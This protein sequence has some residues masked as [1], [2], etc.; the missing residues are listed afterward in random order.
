MSPTAV[1]PEAQDKRC[2]RCALFYRR[3]AARSFAHRI[4]IYFAHHIR[5]TLICDVAT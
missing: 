1:G 4:S 5:S 3:L 2:Y